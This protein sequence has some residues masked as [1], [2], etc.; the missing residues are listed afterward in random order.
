MAKQEVDEVAKYFEIYE[1]Y[2]KSLNEK[3]HSAV[4]IKYNKEN[5]NA[6]IVTAKGRDVLAKKMIAIAKKHNIPIITDSSSVAEL[7]KISVGSEIPYFM[8]EALSVILAYVY[9][10]A[11][12]K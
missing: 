4:A 7:M 2:I 12:D 9:K 1:N 6:P 10:L 3:V 8:Y 11:K 5:D